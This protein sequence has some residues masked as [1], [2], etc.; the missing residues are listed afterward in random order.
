MAERSTVFPFTPEAAL[1]ATLGKHMNV[2]LKC[3]PRAHWP[4]PTYCYCSGF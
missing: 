2:I 4:I 1:S 3:N